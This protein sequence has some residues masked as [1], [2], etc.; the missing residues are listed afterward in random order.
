[1]EDLKLD[2][3]YWKTEND[4]S[5]HAVSYKKKQS[6]DEKTWNAD[7][8]DDLRLPAFFTSNCSKVVY[9]LLPQVR[10]VLGGK[11]MLN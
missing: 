3:L 5:F 8:D 2:D 7:L 1:M 10:E 9:C 11:Q 6:S 4:A